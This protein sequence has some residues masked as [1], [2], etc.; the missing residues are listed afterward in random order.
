MGA[1][2]WHSETR[3]VSECRCESKSCK[4]NRVLECN[5]SRFYCPWDNLVCNLQSPSLVV[6]S[7]RRAQFFPCWIPQMQFYKITFEG[8]QSLLES[9]ITVGL[10]RRN[11]MCN[12][13]IDSSLHAR[14][15][16]P[17]RKNTR[18]RRRGTFQMQL[19]LCR[20]HRRRFYLAD[21]DI[22]FRKV[23][24]TTINPSEAEN[25]YRK[26]L[27]YPHFHVYNVCSCALLLAAHSGTFEIMWI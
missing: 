1:R 13:C 16:T 2:T 26:I 14:R 27:R 12:S 4:F 18:R 24:A 23:S 8:L 6:E 9:W 25:P 15:E 5:P 11:A 19:L 20:N 21:G 3:F 10:T 22:S 7:L 17:K